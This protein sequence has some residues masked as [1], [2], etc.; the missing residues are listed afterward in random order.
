MPMSTWRA[1]L[2]TATR[3]KC[4]STNPRSR[5]CSCEKFPDVEGHTEVIREHP[6]DGLVL[7]SLSQHLVVVGSHGHHALTGTLLGPVSQAVLHHATCPVA[8]V[9]THRN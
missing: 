1:R 7:A 3:P 8:V 5:A 4:S 6:A 9:P 2:L